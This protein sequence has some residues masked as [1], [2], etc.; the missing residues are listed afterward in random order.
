MGTSSIQN[1]G[2]SQG[3]PSVTSSTTTSDQQ[4]VS[5]NAANQFS[6]T[7]WEVVSPIHTSSHYQAFETPFL[8]EL[9]GGDRNMEQTNLVVTSDG[10]TWDEVTRDT[11]YIGNARVSANIDTVSSSHADALF[12]NHRGVNGQGSGDPGNHLFNKDFAI[13]YKGW[14]CLEDG[15]YSMH[16]C[17]YHDSSNTYLE[18][19]LNGNQGILHKNDQSNESSNLTWNVYLK[20]GDYIN[21]RA[22]LEGTAYSYTQFNIRRA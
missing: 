9:V 17:S 1:Q 12:D 10:K 22:H 14:I 2:V 8:Y 11:S 4:S 6:F 5:T 21:V 13:A 19:R 16:L 7:S 20:R 15:F 3:T 18:I